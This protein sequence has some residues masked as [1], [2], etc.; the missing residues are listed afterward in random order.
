LYSPCAGQAASLDGN[1]SRDFVMIIWI[2][3]TIFFSLGAVLIV[4]PIIRRYTVRH[5]TAATETRSQADQ[6]KGVADGSEYDLTRPNGQLS[7][8][9]EGKPPISNKFWEAL[10]L[11]FMRTAVMIAAVSALSA[12]AFAGIYAPI[13]EPAPSTEV[14]PVT[15]LR[16]LAVFSKGP[17]S[18]DQLLQQLGQFAQSD[19]LAQ[20][21][22]TANSNLPPVDKLIERLAARLEKNPKDIQGWRTLGWSYLSLKRFDDAAA[23]YARAIDFFPVVADLYSARGE[24]L[25]AAANDT[26]TADAKQALGEAL[27]L[28]AKEPRA[29]YFLALAKAQ[30]GDKAAALDDWIEL[31]NDVGANDPTI[32]AL[33]QHLAELAKEL[34]VDISKKLHRPLITALGRTAVEPKSPTIGSVP[35][36]KMQSNPKQADVS[37]IVPPAN[38]AVA[39]GD[40]V[41]RLSR[42]LERSPRD[43]D[44]WIMLIRSKKELNDSVA[45]RQAFERALKIFDEGSVERDRLMAAAKSFGLSP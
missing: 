32:P 17:S 11:P 23:A 39:I 3:S 18:R 42:R 2:V 26:V 20:G 43:V 37:A 41:E 24:A 40:M 44:G 19:K 4:T 12:L 45:A 38:Q 14:S 5:A 1:E 35:N 29:R 13:K 31:A 8:S 9:V 33:G 7:A 30:T 16:E 10:E 28:N 25:V 36:A 34:N 27:K 21:V 22:K 15:A 6:T